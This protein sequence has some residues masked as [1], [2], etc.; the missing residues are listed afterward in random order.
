M[1]VEFADK[2]LELIETEKAVQTKL[3]ISVINSARKKLSFIRDAPDEATIRKWKSLHY[4]KLEGDRKGKYSIKINDQYRI[5]FKVDNTC[6]PPKMTVFEI[7][8][9]HY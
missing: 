6:S 1:D 9:Y 5:V 8:D 2:G 4:E 7:T 3:P